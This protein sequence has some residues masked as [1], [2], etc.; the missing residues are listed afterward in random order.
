LKKKMNHFL[1]IRLSSLGDIIHTLPAFAA[2]RKHY[3]GAVIS[4][5]VEEKEKE[6]LDL[7]PGIDRVVA[8]RLKRWKLWSPKFWRELFLVRKKIER[9]DQI[10]IDFQGL[11]KSGLFA[12]FSKAKRRI[13]FQGKDLKEPLAE[14]FYTDKLVRTSKKDHVINKNLELLSLLGIEENRY[15]FPLIVPDELSD[16]IQKMLRNLGYDGEKKLVLLNVGAAWKT[17][18]WYPERW[19]ELIQKLKNEEYFLLLL[20]GNETEKELAIGVSHETGVAVVPSLTLKEV[21]ALVQE[22]SLVVS[23]D[24]FALQ[25]AC[26]FFKPVVGLF[27]P[28]DPG[29]NGPFRPQDRVAFHHL[30]CSFCYK[31]VCSQLECLERISADEV[32]SLCQELLENNV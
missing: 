4:W 24:T 30:D 29:R 23:G 32:V 12:Y 10:A 2:L 1:I 26:A 31:R 14:L 19:S 27:G 8:V 18:R 11:V 5:V 7:V 3:P 25:V 28:T 15:E 17:K 21:I 9:K 16:S 6:I 20:W 22:A 13:G